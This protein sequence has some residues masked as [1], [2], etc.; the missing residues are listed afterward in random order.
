MRKIVNKNSTYSKAYN[1]EESIKKMI[2]TLK[3]IGVSTI[4][5]KEDNPTWNDMDLSLIHI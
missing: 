3:S 4:V 2:D 1:D 5:E